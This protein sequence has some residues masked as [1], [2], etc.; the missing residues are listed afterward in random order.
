MKTRREIKII[1][2]KSVTG[3]GDV[4]FPYSYFLT[5]SPLKD[6]VS[7]V[8]QASTKLQATWLGFNK[9]VKNPVCFLLSF[10]ARLNFLLP[11]C[12]SANHAR[13]SDR[14]SN[15]YYARYLL[16]SPLNANNTSFSPSPSNVYRAR[17][18][19]PSLS[20]LTLA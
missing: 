17:F 15:A 2:S 9:S 5:R 14:P 7:L 10:V 1:I 16:S 8:H 12:S 18:L 6:V 3:K 4:D 13:Y 19:I 11:S 20:K